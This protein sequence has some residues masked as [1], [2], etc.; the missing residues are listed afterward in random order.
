MA[1]D[2]FLKVLSPAGATQAY[3]DDYFELTYTK[4]VNEPGYLRFRLDGNHAKLGTMVQNAQILVMRRD[5]TA[6]LDWYEDF[7]GILRKVKYTTTDRDLFEAECPGHLWLL[8][9]RINAFRAD[10]S[11]RSK[12]SGAKPETIMH[13]LV[14]Y[15]CTSL[16]TTGNSRLRNGAM[17]SPFTITDGTDSARGTNID[18]NNSGVPVLKELSEIA[19]ISL[20]DFDLIR[21]GA[22]SWRFDTFSPRGTDRSSTVSFSLAKGNMADPVY[23]LDTVDEKTVAI[24]AGQDQ[25]SKRQFT[26]RLGQYYSSGTNDIETWVDAKNEESGGLSQQG[27]KALRSLRAKQSF[28]YTIRQSPATVLGRDYFLGDLVKGEYKGISVVQKVWA[29]TMNYEAS[30]GKEDIQVEL[31]DQ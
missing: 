15:N 14:K 19:G 5:R 7:C 25:K 23:E 6:G 11:N 29:Y 24:V 28:T 18:R 8:N 20:V 3:I 17:T 9:W 31:G 1:A 2:Y 30:S 27:D 13:T 4:K 21:T 26:T 12:F 16:A 22:A 10:V